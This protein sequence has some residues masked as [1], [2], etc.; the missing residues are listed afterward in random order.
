MALLQKLVLILK[1]EYEKGENKS[2]M[3][4]TTQKVSHPPVNPKYGVFAPARPLLNIPMAQT[5]L[6]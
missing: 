2:D 1:E 6:M 4:L 5:V 3:M